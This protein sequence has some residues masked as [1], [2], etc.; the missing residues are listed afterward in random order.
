MKKIALSLVALAA[1][2]LPL[3]APAQADSYVDL[4]YEFTNDGDTEGADLVLDTVV[5]SLAG[6]FQMLP[7]RCTPRSNVVKQS[8]ITYYDAAGLPTYAF[9]HDMTFSYNCKVV[10]KLTHRPWYEIFQPQYSFNGYVAN[11]VSPTGHKKGTATAQGRF[12]ICQTTVGSVCLLER[13]PSIVWHVDF[14]GKA[15]AKAT[16]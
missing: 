3:A 12:G 11:S 6:D 13:D 4:G 16:P 14:T 1:A 5:E 15:Y 2:M 10:T 8:V 7:A 9:H